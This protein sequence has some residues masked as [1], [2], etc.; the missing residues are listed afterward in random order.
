MLSC[1]R[2]VLKVATMQETTRFCLAKSNRSRYSQA[3]HVNTVGKDTLFLSWY[4]T[5]FERVSLC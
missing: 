1:P 2:T 4:C 5:G 3:I